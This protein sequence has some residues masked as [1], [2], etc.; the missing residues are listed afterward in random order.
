MVPHNLLNILVC[1]ACKGHLISDDGISTLRCLA[2]NLAFP[3]KEGIPVMLADEAKNIESQN[4]E[5]RPPAS[6][7]LHHGHKVKD[8]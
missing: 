6:D 7:T 4:T 5:A 3:I 1:P 2:C 8:Q